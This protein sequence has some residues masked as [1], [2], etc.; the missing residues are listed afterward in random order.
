M[1]GGGS[2]AWIGGNELTSSLVVV[3]WGHPTHG[4]GHNMKKG[5]FAFSILVT[6]VL[7]SVCHSQTIQGCVSKAGVLRIV[8][9]ASQC[10][11]GET[12]ISWSLG[13]SLFIADNQGNIIGHVV[14][15]LTQILFDSAS[16]KLFFVPAQGTDYDYPFYFY[17]N[18]CSGQ[19]FLADGP[20]SPLNFINQDYD[21]HDFAYRNQGKY[22]TPVGNAMPIDP[23]KKLH[24][25]KYY[26]TRGAYKCED[27]STLHIAFLYNFQEVQMGFKLPISFPLHVVVK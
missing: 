4:E 10:K 14:Q 8:S 22:Y 16:R 20:P 25:L 2:I 6:F 15:F 3:E 21:I 12:P 19:A 23:S 9:A 11:K 27:A 17:D 24:V 13:G 26:H 7:A 5:L 1:I 18:T